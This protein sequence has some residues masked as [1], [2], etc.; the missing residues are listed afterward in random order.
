MAH[1]WSP[2]HGRAPTDKASEAPAESARS[3]CSPRSWCSRANATRR[4]SIAAG[5]WPS[6]SGQ[7][8]DQVLLQLGL[9]TERGLAEAYATLLGAPIAGPARYPEAPLFP[10]PALTPVL[11]HRARVAARG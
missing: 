1:D 4:P 6:E 3:N 5:V 2:R 8:L 7:R 9:V 11:A 10:R